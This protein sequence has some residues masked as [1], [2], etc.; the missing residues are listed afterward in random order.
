MFVFRVVCNFLF[1]VKS[2]TS[3]ATLLFII[4]C[5]GLLFS[6]FI[7]FLVVSCVCFDVCVVFVLFVNCRY[8][9]FVNYLSYSSFCSSIFG[10]V[11]A[12]KFRIM[13]IEY[14]FVVN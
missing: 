5:D 10:N 1:V 14:F 3:F 2:T 13:K 7:V 8:F 11:V 12:V 9:F 4:N 6:V